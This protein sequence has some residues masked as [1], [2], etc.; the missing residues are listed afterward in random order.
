MRDR[1]EES[2]I[3]KLLIDIGDLLQEG[4]T[5]NINIVLSKFLQTLYV[6]TSKI[7]NIDKRINEIDIKIENLDTKIEGRLEDI[8]SSLSSIEGTVN[9]MKK[10]MSEV[11]SKVN[12]LGNMLGALT[13]ATL[14][15]FILEDLKS[16]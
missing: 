15:R 6:L 4:S 13:E 11:Q 7:D 1:P 14:S 16:K 5:V 2:D 8:E 9:D 12:H 10:Q 3:N